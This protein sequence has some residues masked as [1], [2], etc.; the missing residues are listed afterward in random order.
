MFVG[1]VKVPRL[2]GQEHQRKTKNQ[3]WLEQACLVCLGHMDV[4]TDDEER[5]AILVQPRCQWSAEKAS[6]TSALRQHDTT[7]AFLSIKH[8]V[9]KQAANE[10]ALRRCRRGIFQSDGPT[11]LSSEVCHRLPQVTF[12]VVP[13]RALCQVPFDE[14]GRTTVPVL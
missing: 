2:V 3:T 1:T 8:D 13:S 5:R 10:M 7:N 6:V 9:V 12:S 4:W 14:I 11:T